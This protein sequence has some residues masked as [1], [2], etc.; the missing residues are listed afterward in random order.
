MKFAVRPRAVHLLLAIDL[1][2]TALFAA[3]GASMAAQARLDLLGMLVLAFV[4]ALGGGIVRD[5]LIGD[6][7]P[8]AIRNWN[9]AAVALATG[10]AVFVLR[11]S[12][13]GVNHWLVTT[14]DAAGLS[15]FAVAGATKALDFKLNPLLATMMGGI[16]GVGGGTIRDLL[17]GQVPKVLRSDVYA[18]AA[19]FGAAITILCLKLRINAVVASS[20]GIIGCFVLRMLA[21]YRHWNLPGAAGL[22]I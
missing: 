4:T 5:L 8:G 21:V 14:L 22:V 17:I 10:A 3:E 13:A 6:I 18:A 19:L 7:P 20:C 2:G 16:T 15:F 11:A 12:T 1:V 9:Y